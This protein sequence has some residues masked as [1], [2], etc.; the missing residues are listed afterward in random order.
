MSKIIRTGRVSGSG[1]VTLGRHEEGLYLDPAV[2]RDKAPEID[3]EQ[4]MAKRLQ[5]LTDG[6][7]K[8][9]EGRMR[10]EHDTTRTAGERQLAEAVERHE[11]ELAS[12]HQGR[13]DE[14]YGDGVSAKEDEARDAVARVEVLH[15][16]MRHDRDQ[17]LFEA[18]ILVVDLALAVARRITRV[19][20][21]TDNMTVARTVRAALKHL[22]ERSNLVIRVHPDDLQIARR[23][24]SAWVERVDIDAVLR[25]QASDHVDRGGCMVEGGEENVDARLASQLDVLQKALRDQVEETHE[26][27]A[28]EATDAPVGAPMDASVD[29][30]G[31]APA[32]DALDDTAETDESDENV[33]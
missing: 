32:D 24:S 33:S 17:V 5:N 14:G 2:P 11:A 23:F 3:L 7:D 27:D 8:A 21:E 10:Q 30:S 25:V 15:K 4:I 16:A 12:V 18:E 22:S 26:S 13:Y 31:D 1:V 19:Q 29:D 20:A 9:W 6:L 28:A